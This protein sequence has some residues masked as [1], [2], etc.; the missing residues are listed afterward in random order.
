MCISRA[1]Y[2]SDGRDAQRGLGTP[3]QCRI[4]ISRSPRPLAEIA[5]RQ[6]TPTQPPAPGT[7]TLGHLAANTIMN[8]TT[9][10]EELAAFANA[11]AHLEPDGVPRH[12]GASAAAA[13]GP[14]PG[15][16]GVHPRSRSHRIETLDDTADQI[17]W[18]HHWIA[19]NGRLVRHSAP[20]H[21]IWPPSPT[22]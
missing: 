12:R 2:T 13:P 15:R 11:A 5:P 20:R 9:Q 14:Q 10:D 21:Y 1:E 17:A 16:L 8:V 18:S 3:F 7:L 6:P 19:A 22:S 4:R